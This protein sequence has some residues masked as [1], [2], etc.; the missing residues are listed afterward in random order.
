VELVGARASE[1]KVE[2]IDPGRG[3]SLI[4]D[5]NFKLLLGLLVRFELRHN[6]VAAGKAGPLLPVEGPDFQRTRCVCGK[7]VRP[8]EGTKLGNRRAEG[9]GIIRVLT[10]SLVTKASKF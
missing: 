1:V 5:D 9:L 4:L 2:V 7:A 8:G 3:F 10:C 6:E